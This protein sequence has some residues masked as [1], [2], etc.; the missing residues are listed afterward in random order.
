MKKPD[1]K[2]E[3]GQALVEFAII[4]PLLLTIVCGILDFGWIY[5]NQYKIENAAYSGSRYASI[6]VSSYDSS[7]MNTLIANTKQRVKENLWNQGK[8]ATI[9]VQVE[10]DQVSVT[11]NYPVKNLTFVAQ[12]IY[13]KYFNAS[14][15]SVAAF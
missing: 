2:R 14:S 13:G 10:N 5:S 4:L 9:S 3:S 15:T 11:V 6:N 7:T 1:K 8:D 12:S